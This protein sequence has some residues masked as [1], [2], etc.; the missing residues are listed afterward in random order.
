[1][2]SFARIQP[3]LSFLSSLLSASLFSSSTINANAIYSNESYY[4]Q[5]EKRDP[6]YVPA[7]IALEGCSVKSRSFA[8]FKKN[9]GIQMGECYMNAR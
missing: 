9:E 8:T 2:K 1:M 4:H 6:S 3:S 7:N 5:L